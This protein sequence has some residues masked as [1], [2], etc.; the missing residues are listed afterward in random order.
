MGR[1]MVR[2]LMADHQ[3]TTGNS[4]FEELHFRFGPESI[5]PRVVQQRSWSP[6]VGCRYHQCQL[7]ELVRAV[8]ET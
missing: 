6:V 8:S 5:L 2:Q 4:S 3:Y 1:R 7:L